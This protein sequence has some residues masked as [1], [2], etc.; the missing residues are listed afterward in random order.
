MLSAG[1][2]GLLVLFQQ[3]WVHF[4]RAQSYVPAAVV[5]TSA[6]PCF[7]GLVWFYARNDLCLLLHGFALSPWWKMGWIRANP[8]FESSPKRRHQADEGKTSPDPA[9]IKITLR[10]VSMRMAG[11]K[12]DSE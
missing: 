8:L 1:F 6:S 10:N 5:V 2:I 9:F 3:R 4:C 11:S 7:P 12:K